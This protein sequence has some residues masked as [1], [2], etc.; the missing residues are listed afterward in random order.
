MREKNNKVG[1]LGRIPKSVFSLVFLFRPFCE[2]NRKR[3]DIVPK[4]E[5]WR[6]EKIE[7]ENDEVLLYG[8]IT[9]V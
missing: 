5:H 3:L 4:N 9:K 6:I 8:N 1:Y 7:Y 2:S